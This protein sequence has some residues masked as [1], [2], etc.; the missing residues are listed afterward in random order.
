MEKVDTVRLIKYITNNFQSSTQKT[1]FFSG[2][3]ILKE[4]FN[5]THLMTSNIYVRMET[6]TFV[7]VNTNGELSDM[8][9]TALISSETYVQIR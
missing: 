9:K 5:Y 3:R 7:G 8:V 6:V 1:C 2:L 4:N